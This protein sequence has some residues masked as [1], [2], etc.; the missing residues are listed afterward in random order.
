MTVKLFLHKRCGKQTVYGKYVHNE[1]PDL[2]KGLIGVD[3]IPLF[4]WIIT[5]LLLSLLF[6]YL[7]F[8][9][10]GNLNISFI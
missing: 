1:L 10:N 7:V 5:F 6:K 2:R 9:N 3:E 4:K 8:I